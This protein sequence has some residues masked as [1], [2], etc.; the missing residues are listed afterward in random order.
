MKG[1]EEADYALG[2]AQRMGAEY[3]EAYVESTYSKFSA[4]EQGH[5]N[6]SAQSEETGLR[7]RFV[8]DARLYTISTNK[9]EKSSIKQL[10]MRFRA[11]PGL[12]TH[13][14]AESVEK[15]NYKVAEKQSIEDANMLED[16]L[17]LDKELAEMKYVKYR[18]LYGGVGR[19][20]PYY[21]N[22]DG[23]SI[24]SSVPSVSASVWSLIKP[25][26]DGIADESTPV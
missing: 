14:S 15:A 25:N 19:S 3:A 7:I 4:V 10:I 21:I 20:N 8:K 2:V 17:K 9:L 6:A 12:D 26:C 13:L 5:V 22:S 16:L 1:T 24:R 18:S 11:F 23:S